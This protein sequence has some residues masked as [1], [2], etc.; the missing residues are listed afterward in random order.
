[1]KTL[2]KFSKEFSPECYFKNPETGEEGWEIFFPVVIS[3]SKKE[4]AD[5]ILKMPY[6]DCFICED[7]QHFNIIN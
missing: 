2:K 6:F 3:T 4:A 7:F 1:M 5:I